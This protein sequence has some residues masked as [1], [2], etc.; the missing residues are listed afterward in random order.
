MAGVKGY[1][2]DVVSKMP[3]QVI[4]V[5]VREG[6]TVTVGQVIVEIDDDELQAELD[7]LTARLE[8]AMQR[9]EQARV[10]I[11]VLPK[12]SRGSRA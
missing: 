7:R 9:A 10:R 1:E 11:T 6:D 4:K 2:T 5:T 12:S 3:G 8:T